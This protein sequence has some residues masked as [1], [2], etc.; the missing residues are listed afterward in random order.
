MKAAAA[1]L[2]TYWMAEV[3][4]QKLD[5]NDDQTRI[6][7]CM[8]FILH[9]LVHMLCINGKNMLLIGMH[10]LLRD[11]LLTFLGLT[12]MYAIFAAYGTLGQHIIMNVCVFSY[13]LVILH[14]LCWPFFRRSLDIDPQDP[15]EVQVVL[16]KAYMTY[17]SAFDR[18]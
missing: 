11:V 13:L 16:E 3:A 18:I 14:G 8:F 2:M 10:L 5:T 15:F 4:V 6:L 17:R 12:E 1:R 9:I 7:V